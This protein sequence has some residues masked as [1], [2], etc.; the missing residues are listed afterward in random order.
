MLIPL[1]QHHGK[2]PLALFKTILLNGANTPVIELYDPE[3]L[4]KSNSS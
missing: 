4:P 1:F 3:N 2:V